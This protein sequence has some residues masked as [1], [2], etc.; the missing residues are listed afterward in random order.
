MTTSSPSLAPA[1]VS[2]L[3]PPALGELIVEPLIVVE[4]LLIPEGSTTKFVAL[5]DEPSPETPLSSTNQLTSD[6][7]EDDPPNSI[8]DSLTIDEVPMSDRDAII[9]NGTAEFIKGTGQADWIDGRGGG[10]TI[11]G[12]GGNDTIHGG[13][14]SDTVKG[15][16]GDDTLRGQGGADELI[17][18]DGNDDLD[19]GAGADVLRGKKGHDDL[20]GGGGSD[21][22]FGGDGNDELFGG[23][24]N[25]TL[26]GGNG[27][28]TFWLGPN[29]GI[30]TITDWGNGNDIQFESNPDR[31]GQ[32]LAMLGEFII[33]R[34][35][36]NLYLDPDAEGAQE[37]ELVAHLPAGVMARDIRINV[38]DT[39]SLSFEQ[40][41]DL[42]LVSANVLGSLPSEV[43]TVRD[44]D[45]LDPSRR[46]NDL[47]ARSERSP[48]SPPSL[49]G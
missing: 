3:N 26:N 7:G 1:I 24:G 36:G 12:E 19:G 41:S 18:G 22:L 37:P 11:K 4:P 2:D 44:M 15:G 23:A 42:S 35:T 8:D 45:T 10:D 49:L 13:T 46:P 31:K 38:V 28:D 9:G 34:L 14:G 16:S 39:T 20:F 27:N 17:G 25:D 6:D 43:A 21:S 40:R 47:V 33:D 29:A 32:G 30:D 48:L 5:P